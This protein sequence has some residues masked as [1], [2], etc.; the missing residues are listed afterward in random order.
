MASH[1]TG[2][3]IMQLVTQIKDFSDILPPGTSNSK[4]GDADYLAM[5][6]HEIGTPLASIIGLSHILTN[7]ECSPQK[8]K[9]C[10]EMLRESSN[11]LMELMKNMLDA[12]KMDAGMIEIEQISFDLAQVVQEAVHIIAAKAAEKGLELHVH[13]ADGLPQQLIGDSLRI[14][15]ILLNLLSNA[16]KFTATGNVTLY[17]NGVIGDEGN[18]QLCITVV[19]TGIGIS[20]ESLKRIFDKYA[21]GHASIGRKYGGTGLG[22]SI[23]Q[24]LAHLMHGDIAVKSWPG[25]GSHFILTLPMQKIT[26]LLAAA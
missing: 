12:S 14:R 16:V 11:M 10:A 9:E 1:F 7:V 20:E 3:V 17:V 8:K 21:Q 15:Q 5:M 6:C 18:D 4:F 19:D 26:A 2:E 25:M 23:S 22:L 24:D 13:I